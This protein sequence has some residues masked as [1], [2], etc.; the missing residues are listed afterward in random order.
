[1]CALTLSKCNFV[2]FSEKNSFKLDGVVGQTQPH[3]IVWSDKSN[4]IASTYISAES[5]DIVYAYV[6]SLHT[7]YSFLLSAVCPTGQC[8]SPA[9]IEPK[10][11]RLTGTVEVKQHFEGV[12]KMLFVFLFY[13]LRATVLGALPRTSRIE[14]N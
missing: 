11:G 2:N 14:M 9:N 7:N 6:S 1:M 3:V 5:M 12:R 4:V 8:T 13:C 10:N